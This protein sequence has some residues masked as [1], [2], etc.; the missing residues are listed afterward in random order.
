[1]V[2][3]DTGLAR[4]SSRIVHYLAPS[5][6]GAGPAARHHRAGAV[7]HRGRRRVP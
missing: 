3:D 7:G 5:P 2:P 1:M 6:P 4:S